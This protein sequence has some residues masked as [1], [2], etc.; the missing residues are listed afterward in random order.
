MGARCRGGPSLVWSKAIA[1]SRR[2]WYIIRRY[3]GIVRGP[4]VVR[5]VSSGNTLTW[6]L[7]CNRVPY[8]EQGPRHKPN[9]SRSGS[10]ES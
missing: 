9:R 5:V 2:T 3:P 1:V 4:A 10:N 6:D 7:D 8:I